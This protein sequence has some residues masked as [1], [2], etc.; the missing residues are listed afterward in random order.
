MYQNHAKSLLMLP[1]FIP[2]QPKRGGV[3]KQNHMSIAKI[4][5]LHVYVHVSCS[6]LPLHGMIADMLMKYGQIL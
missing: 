1:P 4:K 6:N 2:S 3:Q 5:M